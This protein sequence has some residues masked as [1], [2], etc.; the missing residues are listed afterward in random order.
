M[1]AQGGWQLGAVIGM[2]ARTVILG[3]VAV[4]LWSKGR[5]V[6]NPA[7]YGRQAVTRRML[8]EI[9]SAERSHV[10]DEATGEDGFYAE[11]T[12]DEL[13]AIYRS[14]DRDRAPE[15]FSELVREARRRDERSS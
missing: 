9:A 11:E 8:A 5:A 12:D 6:L 3:G 14:I 7:L 15:R 2:V 4:L 13:L 10:V 1:I